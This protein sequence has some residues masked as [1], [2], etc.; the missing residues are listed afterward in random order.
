LLGGKSAFLQPR[1]NGVDLLAMLFEI[2]GG[3]LCSPG[4]LF[5]Y[6]G[7]NLAPETGAGF[8]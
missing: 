4:G 8:Q 3:E 6:D 2:I 7:I 1:P 5:L